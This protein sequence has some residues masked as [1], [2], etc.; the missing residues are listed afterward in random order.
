MINQNLM[1]SMGAETRE[2]YKDA[3]L[4]ILLDRVQ[5]QNGLLQ[6]YHGSTFM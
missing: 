6:K 2:K 1:T 3:V 4:K 5:M